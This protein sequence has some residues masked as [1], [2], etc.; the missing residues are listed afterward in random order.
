MAINFPLSATTSWTN[1]ARGLVKTS[2]ELQNDYDANASSWSGT[3]TR[4]SSTASTPNNALLVTQEDNDTSS[5]FN[6]ETKPVLGF[7]SVLSKL[8]LLTTVEAAEGDIYDMAM[9]KVHS[10]V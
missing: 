7:K 9:H 4:A 6:N 3:W 1:S 5:T 8:G 2:Q 10:I